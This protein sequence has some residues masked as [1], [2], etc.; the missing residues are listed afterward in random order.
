MNQM[1]IAESN[2]QAYR[3]MK[4]ALD[5]QFPAGHF[6]AIEGG[7]VVADAATVQEL[8][9][10][11]FRSGKNPSDVFVVEAGAD[12]PQFATILLSRYSGRAV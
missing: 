12:Y 10:L 6:I 9:P 5:A 8:R 2:E 4:P 1:Q 11:L 3:R 7:E